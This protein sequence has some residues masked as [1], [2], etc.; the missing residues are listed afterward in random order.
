MVRVGADDDSL[1]VQPFQQTIS[2]G[3][4]LGEAI[5]APIAPVIKPIYGQRIS[6][7]LGIGEL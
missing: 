4:E 3:D 7:I 2:L 1:I 6:A 5:R